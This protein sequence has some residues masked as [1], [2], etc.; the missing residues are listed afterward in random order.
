MAPDIVEN[1]FFWGNMKEEGNLHTQMSSIFRAKF[2]SW[3]S[4]DDIHQSVSSPIH[5]LKWHRFELQTPV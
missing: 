2:S 3:V 4:L 5:V 1:M